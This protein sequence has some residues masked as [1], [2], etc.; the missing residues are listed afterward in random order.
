MTMRELLQSTHDMKVAYGLV[1]AAGPL[2]A[3]ALIW[4][5]ATLHVV[6]SLSGLKRTVGLS[7]NHSVGESGSAR[8]ITG[9]P[10]KQFV[11]DLRLAENDERFRHTIQLT[12]LI[13]WTADANG[14]LQSIARTKFGENG[15]SLEGALKDGWWQLIHPDDLD[16]TLAICSEARSSVS[17]FLSDQRIRRLDG[18]YDWWRLRGVPRTTGDGS[19]ICWYGTLNKIDDNQEALSQMR[20]L[21]SDLIRASRAN[22]MGAIASTIAHELNQPLT[23]IANYVRGSRRSLPEGRE[24]DQIRN[25]L[26]A[27]DENAVRAGE[28]VHRVRELVAEGSAER[29]SHSLRKL[30]DDA[31]GLAM[32][33][34]HSAGIEY[35]VEIDPNLPRVLANNVQIQQVLFNL[36]RNAT[37]ALSQSN[38]RTIVIAAALNA[39]GFCIVTVTDSGPAFLLKINPKCF[40]Q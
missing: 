17:E 23:A 10:A 35:R 25:A 6:R 11:E 32:I 12:S 27:A 1:D 40:N 22:G 34:A 4:R 14:K 18:T 9:Q 29:T 39:D 19:V 26:S 21:Q 7:P 36:L 13:T 28:I 15:A 31:C 5:R 8:I 33:D 2:A 37:E 24:F 30:V 38:E 20:Q 3:S 16:G